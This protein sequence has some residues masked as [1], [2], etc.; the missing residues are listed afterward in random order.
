MR[1]KNVL[2]LI[3]SFEQGGSERQAVQLSRLLRNEGSFRV[4]V[5]CLDR[6]GG[7]LRE[8]DWLAAGEIPEFKLTSFYDSNFLRQIRCCAAFIR[9]NRISVVHTHDFYTNIFGMLAASLARVPARVASKRETFSKTRRQMLVE[10]Q[11]FR[12]AHRIVVN[13]EAVKSFLCAAGVPGRKAKV[14]YNGLDLW[15]LTAS[16]VERHE[17]LR[18]LNLPELRDSKI[19]TMVAN[20]RSEVKNHRMFL[21]VAKAVAESSDQVHFVAAGEG[22]L[23]ESLRAFARELGVEQRAHFIGAC[24]D[25]P[26]LLSVSDICVLTSRSEGF[27]NAV[28]EYMSAAKPVVA[29]RVGGAAEAVVDGETGFLVDSDDDAAMALRVLEL[30]RNPEMKDRLGRQG[31]QIVEEKFT[32]A[33][34]LAET[35]DLYNEL[36]NGGRAKSRSTAA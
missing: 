34:Q 29:T 9:E 8:I 24:D 19:I 3:G 27:S 31:R 5:G 35:L 30:L 21:R 10:R 7:L 20:L 6:S 32:L 23:L 15:R 1:A 4:F 2:Q 16:R 12:L 11:A 25:V 14:I 36:L 33:R 18:R 22:E 28:L 17:L 26:A 13:A